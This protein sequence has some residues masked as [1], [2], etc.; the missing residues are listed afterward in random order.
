MLWIL[1]GNVKC[2]KEATMLKQRIICKSFIIST[3]LT[4]SVYAQTEVA[5]QNILQQFHKM[6]ITHCD[7]FI[8]KNIQAKGDWKFFLS[9]HAGGLDGPSTEVSMVQIY[10][11]KTSSFKNDYTF[12]QTLKK[13]FLHK[14]GS[15]FAKEPCASAVDTE[16]WKIQFNLPG[17]SYK[18]YKNAKG[19][20]L[21]S[22]AITADQCLLEYEYRTKGEHSLYK[23]K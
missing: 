14:R 1:I 3:L 21:Y 4:T 2:N 19:I 13:C 12:V 7:E 8:E 10:G 17:Y 6:G 11:D 9:K 15:I 16:Q 20:V 22:N 23:Q 5:N 18:R